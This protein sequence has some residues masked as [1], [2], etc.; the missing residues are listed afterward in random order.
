MPSK[1]ESLEK[2]SIIFKLCVLQNVLKGWTQGR[3][4]KWTFD[5]A[6]EKVH[7][8][9]LRV[10]RAGQGCKGWDKR[11]EGWW[12]F[13]GLIREGRRESG[14]RKPYCQEKMAEEPCRKGPEP[15]PR[16]PGA[17]LFPAV[18]ASAESG[19]EVTQFHLNQPATN[20]HCECWPTP[21]EFLWFIFVV[22]IKLK[23][24]TPKGLL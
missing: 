23:K 21:G 11:A 16:V 18:V 10:W 24:T 12:Q 7:I 19:R 5:K 22:C 20:T 8:S 14:R 4:S 15:S 2:F 17:G 13:Y 3:M 6:L 9:A 1:S